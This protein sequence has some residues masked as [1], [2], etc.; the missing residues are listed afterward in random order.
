MI[1][2]SDLAG[3]SGSRGVRVV[4]R[5]LAI[6]LLLSVAAACARRTAPVTPPATPAYPQFPFPAVT[7]DLARTA[8]TLT[9][10][11]QRAWSLLQTGRADQAARDFERVLS[12]ES[13]FYPAATGLGFSELAQKQADAALEHFDRALGHA[14]AYA[15]ALLGRAE[16][17]LMLQRDGDALAAYEAALSA[18]PGLTNVRQR[19]EVIRFR[20]VQADVAAAEQARQRGELPRARAYY[21]RAITASP[22]SG[23]LYRDLAQV[24]RELGELDRALAH[25]ERAIALDPS[26]AVSYQVLGQL[27]EQQGKRDAA[28][29]A[30][31]EAASLDPTLDVAPRIEA[32][33]ARTEV[34]RLPA[35]YQ[36]IP[37]AVAIGRGDLAAMFGIRLA[38][39]IE[40]ASQSSVLL[41]DTRR[42]WAESWILGVAQSGIMDVYGNHTFQPE[43]RLTRGELATAASRVLALIGTSRPALAASWDRARQ[44]FADMESSHLLYAEA[45]R[46]VAAGIMRVREDGTFAPAE[47]VSGSEAVAAVERLA[48]L[49]EEAGLTV[50]HE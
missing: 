14:P 8:G 17:L 34:E 45:S 49:A 41:T 2:G 15:P 43:A 32:L 29:A 13:T 7:D 31:R 25:V 23:F 16:T 33:E 39:V 3:A 1:G 27:R 28:L 19:I 11:H 42:H 36:T 44:S 20:A 18:D 6:V 22:E 37:G 21:Q 48:Q 26:D 30:Y 12:R 46:A 9:T 5:A 24:E 50:N 38:P 35:A 47:T 40:R 4:S 10:D